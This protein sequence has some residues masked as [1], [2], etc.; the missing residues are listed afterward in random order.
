MRKIQ[1]H[2]SLWTSIYE[3]QTTGQIDKA[4]VWQE[5]AAQFYLTIL[6]GKRSPEEVLPMRMMKEPIRKFIETFFF[7]VELFI[8]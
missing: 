6:R 8:L 7:F 4:Y 1:F 5:G 3:N 2:E